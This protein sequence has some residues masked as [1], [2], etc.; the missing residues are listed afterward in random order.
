MVG[1]I[2]I[3]S[4]TGLIMMINA[5]IIAAVLMSVAATTSTAVEIYQ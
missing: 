3:G 4:V 1:I 2:A 5:I